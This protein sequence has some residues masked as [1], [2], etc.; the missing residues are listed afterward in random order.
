MSLTNPPE[1]A[2]RDGIYARCLATAFCAGESSEKLA[3][4]VTTAR[5]RKPKPNKHQVKTEE[6]A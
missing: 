2:C 3:S 1:I 4:S 5:H 6:L